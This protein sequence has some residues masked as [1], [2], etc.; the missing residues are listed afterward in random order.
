MTEITNELMY[1][2]LKQ[3]QATLAEVKSTQLEHSRQLILVTALHH[4]RM[5]GV[6]IGEGN[7]RRRQF[8]A[9]KRFADRTD[10]LLTRCHYPSL[11]VWQTNRETVRWGFS[12]SRALWPIP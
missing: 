1:G 4:I 7:R 10:K 12:V 8:R 9:A 6:A 11:C 3:I 5:Y 2:V